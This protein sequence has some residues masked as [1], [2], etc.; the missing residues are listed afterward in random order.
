MSKYFSLRQL[1]DGFALPGSHCDVNDEI[2]GLAWDSRKVESGDLFFAC[3]GKNIHGK[4]FIQKAVDAG[5]AAIAL[6]T[7]DASEATSISD[8][9]KIPVVPVESLTKKLGLIAARF[10]DRPSSHLKLI[11]V[12]GTNGK[13]SCTH[14]LAQCLN[15][16]EH[17]C[18]VV[19]TMGAGIWGQLEGIANTTPGAVELQQRLNQLANQHAK[20][21]AMEVSS[22]GLEQGRTIGCEFNI[23]VFTNLTQ[24]HLDY[25][26]DMQTYGDVK[27]KLF[28]NPGLDGVV[29]NLDDE[30]SQTIIDTVSS[31]VVVTGITLNSANKN[32]QINNVDLICG[33]ITELNAQGMTINIKCRAGEGELKTNLLGD[34]NASNLLTVFACVVQLGFSFDESLEKLARVKAPDGRLQRFGGNDKPLVVVDYAHTPDALEKVLLTLKKHTE[35]NL[36]VLIGCGGDRDKSKRPLMGAVAEEHADV[37]W[38]TNDN[39]RS[40]SPEAIVNDI[41]H[42]IK[43]QEQ[44][45]VELDR[46]IAIKGLIKTAT[47]NDVVLIAGKGHEDYQI[48]GDQKLDFSDSKIVAELIGEAA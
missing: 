20:Y 3:D 14:L 8:K 4:Q 46:E 19:G 9:Y 11:G 35:G 36:L 15:A 24:D 40:E 25:H 27:L 17:L 31:D 43:N 39:P 21:V 23:A 37:V 12:T 5:A 10:Y 30:F 48:I 44:I 13:T 47:N 45:V 22:H 18:G 7:S 6:E 34:F 42:G 38:L 26:G 1:L 29:I 33:E 32:K 2:N 16:P 41:L 28:K